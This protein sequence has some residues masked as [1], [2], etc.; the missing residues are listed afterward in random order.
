MNLLEKEY[1]FDLIDSKST[2][3]QN[4]S[5]IA[6]LNTYGVLI[7]YLGYVDIPLERLS[8]YKIVKIDD[9]VNYNERFD[10]FLRRLV[11]NSNMVISPY[12]YAL[13]RHFRHSNVVWLPY[14]SGIERYGNVTFNTDPVR[15]VFASGSVAW[16]RPFRQYAASRKSENIDVLAHPGYRPYDDNSPEIIGEKYYRELNKYLCCFCD[17]HKYRYMHLRNFEIASVG[18]LLLGDRLIEKE[19]NE[20]GFVDYETCIFSDRYDFLEK[21]SWICDEKNRAD[22]DKIRRAGMKLVGERHLTRH[23]AKQLND[24]VNNAIRRHTSAL[25]AAEGSTTAHQT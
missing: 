3:F 5:V 24:L 22:V 7:L 20:L 8:A 1:G 11:D 10:K 15:K 2:D 13:Q 23:R 4:A 14:S 12:A 6:K 18:S 21:V 9:L 19:M 16:D 25:A 17:A